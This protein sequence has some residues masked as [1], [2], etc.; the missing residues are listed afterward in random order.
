ML[1]LSNLPHENAVKRA[2]P[3]N[4]II[5]RPIVLGAHFCLHDELLRSLVT[6][7]ESTFIP[8]CQHSPISRSFGV[9]VPIFK[10]NTVFFYIYRE[11]ESTVWIGYKE[12]KGPQ[13]V[14]PRNLFISLNMCTLCRSVSV[15]SGII[16]CLIFLNYSVLVRALIYGA[17]VSSVFPQLRT[18]QL[19]SAEFTFTH[20]LS[21]TYPRLQTLINALETPPHHTQ[22]M[23][24]KFLFYFAILLTLVFIQNI[25]IIV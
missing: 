21:R 19:G 11:R 18:G 22:H 15:S 16:V 9:G 3:A 1:Q 14:I 20:V 13:S 5:P 17:S 12:V 10:Y 2:F 7:L 24:M 4:K 8:E 23:T 25:Y 6:T